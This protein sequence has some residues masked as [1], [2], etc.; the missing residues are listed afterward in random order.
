MSKFKI[1]EV[2][3][4]LPGFHNIFKKPNYAGKAYKENLVL[5][6]KF[7]DKQRGNMYVYFFEEMPHGIYEFALESIIRYNRNNT[8][9]DILT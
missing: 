5:R 8:I 2:V 4:T 3:H 9:D 1:G 7:V 6:I